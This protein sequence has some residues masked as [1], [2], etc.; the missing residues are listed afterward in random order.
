[1]ANEPARRFI[2]LTVSVLASGRAHIASSSG[3]HPED[4]PQAWG[5]REVIV[6]TGDYE[7]AEWRPQGNRIGWLH[8]HDGERDDV[9]VYLDPNAAY[10]AAQT[11]GRE[12]GDQLTVTPQTLRKRLNERGLLASTDQTRKTLTVRRT[13][14]GQRRDV[15]HLYATTLELPDQYE[16]KPDQE[17]RKP[18]QRA[19]QKPDHGPQTRQPATEHPPSSQ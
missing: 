3:D 10:A 15:L 13:L 19:D 11:L 5:W 14:E 16:H 1:M 2:E 12:I 18:D 17:R 7:R 6:G 4:S 9:D 8:D